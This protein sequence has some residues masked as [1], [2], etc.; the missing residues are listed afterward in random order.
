MKTTN[1]DRDKPVR[2]GAIYC[3][4]GCGAKCT[5]KAFIAAKKRGR[6]LARLL[7]PSWKAEVWENLGWHYAAKS[8]VGTVHHFGKTHFWADLNADGRQVEADGRTPIAALK[9]AIDKA[10]QTRDAMDALLNSK[11]LNEQ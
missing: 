6:E 9:A 3:S 5:W 11:P 8:S 4:P 2:N 1:I 10:A 7:G